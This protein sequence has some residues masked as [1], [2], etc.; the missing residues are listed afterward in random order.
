MDVLETSELG[1]VFCHVS[2][3]VTTGSPSESIPPQFPRQSELFKSKSL[4]VKTWLGNLKV[5]PVSGEAQ[6]KAFSFYLLASYCSCFYKVLLKHSQTQQSGT[7]S[8]T[9]TIWPV[10]LT[11]LQLT[12]H[13][14]WIQNKNFLTCLW[15]IACVFYFLCQSSLMLWYI[16]IQMNCQTY[17]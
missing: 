17:E 8:P 12:F 4:L 2:H 1:G 7:D 14:H 11:H 3:P 9:E 10:S 13:R 5:L 15:W 16:L 6:K